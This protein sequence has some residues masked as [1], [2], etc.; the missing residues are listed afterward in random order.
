MKTALIQAKEVSQFDGEI[1]QKLKT[2]TVDISAVKKERM[3]VGIRNE[4]REIYRVIGITGLDVF[5][6]AIGDLGSL[7][8][9]D[10]LE[11]E[12]NPKHGCDAIFYRP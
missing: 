1:L 7:N 6:D 5:L 8:L 12:T 4:Q 2:N 10:E 9:V 11:A 3:I